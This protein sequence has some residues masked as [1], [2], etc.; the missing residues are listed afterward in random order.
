[1]Y[2][3]TAVFQGGG[4]LGA[5][6]C[7]V[8]K[9]RNINYDLCIGTSTGA[10]LAPFVVLGMYDE[11]I[12]MYTNVTAKDIFDVNPFTN[13]GRVS[14]PNAIWRLIRGKKT[15]GENNNIRKLIESKFT[16]EL[17]NK[18]Q[19][20]GKNVIV[21]VCNITKK[22]HQTEYISIYDVDYKTFCDYIWASTS[23][24]LVTSLVRIGDYE[25]VDG[26]TTENLPLKLAQEMTSGNI[27]CYFHNERDEDGNRSYIQD[28]AHLATRTFNI[29]REETRKDDM[30]SGL[31]EGLIVKRN[32][33]TYSY[34][35]YKLSE[36]PLVFDKKQMLEWVNLGLTKK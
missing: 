25:Y 35:P 11:L 19:S 18:I 5:Y 22:G 13:K 8:L 23:V 16:I 26:G 12:D 4:S 10:L 9:Q 30:Q 33:I 15:L 1:M 32:T 29:I 28:I 3:S 34:L 14:I 2:N 21:T 27:D 36:N 6:T 31:Q 24:P 7:G 20:Q 17:Y